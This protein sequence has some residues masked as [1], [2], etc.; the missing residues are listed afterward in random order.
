MS[1]SELRTMLLGLEKTLEAL[2][3][4]LDK[5]DAEQWAVLNELRAT[6]SSIN[7]LLAKIEAS[8]A[9]RCTTRGDEIKRLQADM[10]DLKQ[11]VWSFSG[12]AVIAT[13]IISMIIKKVWP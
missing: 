8:L 1:E 11:R 7:T 10:R 2:E 4:R 5:E 3:K 9:E 12:M 13:L 6:L